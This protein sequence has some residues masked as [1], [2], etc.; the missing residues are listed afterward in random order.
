MHVTHSTSIETTPRAARATLRLASAKAALT[1]WLLGVEPRTFRRTLAGLPKCLAHASAYARQSPSE[2]S[3]PIGKCDLHPVLGEHRAGA[4]GVTGHYFHQD[5]WAARKIFMRPPAEHLDVGSRIDAFV[6]HVLTFMRA[7]VI[8]V[9]PLAEHVDGLRFIHADATHFSNIADATL[10]SVLSRHA[11]EHFGLGRCGSRF[12]H[13]A[14]EKA[15]AAFSLVLAPGGRLYFSVP[16]GPERLMF[17]A[18]RIFCPQTV[19]RHLSSLDLIPFA[20]VYVSG[21]FQPDV[22]RRDF[23]GAEYSCGLFEFGRV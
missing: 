11:D 13:G 14:A 6:A 8:D 9:R 3:F 21:H 2:P 12:D 20:A 19:L 18:H 10:A 23:E 7:T 1:P 5:L 22:D 4:G 16:I 17:S 15:M